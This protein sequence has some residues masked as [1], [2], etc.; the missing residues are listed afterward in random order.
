MSIYQTIAE[1][2]KTGK[3]AVFCTIVDAKGSTPRHEGSKMLVFPDGHIQG[4][5]GG[6]ETERRVI[7]EALDALSRRVTKVLHYQLVNPANGDPGVCGGQVEVYVEPIIPKLTIVVVGAGHVGRQVVFLAKWL[8]YRVVVSDDRAEM[9]TAEY[10]PGADEFIICPMAELP[11]NIEVNPYTY[12]VI[13]TRGADVDIE[14]LP[15]ILDTQAAYIGVIGSLRRWKHTVDEINKVK[16]YN[17]R[18]ATVHS[19][20][21]LELN[22]E[23]PE[24]I[25][26]SILAEIMKVAN[27][28]SGMSMSER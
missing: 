2:E 26:I 18:L 20:M 7:A 19:P 22:A 10:M 5:V 4:T 21:G 17:T 14:G 15:S 1:L 13:T 24:E 25:A 16:D 11:T 12:F 9:C 28:A 6:G 23:T 8:G 3:P 27:S